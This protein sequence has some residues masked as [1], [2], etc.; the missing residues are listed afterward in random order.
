MPEFGTVPAEV[1][2]ILLSQKVAGR[3]FWNQVIDEIQVS[4]F[5]GWDES[6][7]IRGH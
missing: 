6:R 1:G 5:G 7:E 4:A 2:L 3:L